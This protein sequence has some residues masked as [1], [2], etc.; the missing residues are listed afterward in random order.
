MA[1][2]DAC[3]F[4]SGPGPGLRSARASEKLA[5]LWGH[6]AAVQLLNKN[7]PA[8]SGCG[9]AFHADTQGALS[10]ERIMRSWRIAPVPDPAGPFLFSSCRRKPTAPKARPISPKPGQTA[11]RDRT[12]NRRPHN[13][14]SHCQRPLPAAS[15]AHHR[16]SLA[17]YLE[18]DPNPPLRTPSASSSTVIPNWTKIPCMNPSPAFSCRTLFS[19]ESFV[20]LAMICPSLS[21]LK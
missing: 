9:A 8:G 6:W 7:G 13:R 21:E 5:V 1:G 10:R 17:H 3:G 14:P 19:L 16:P 12:G 4:S 11:S 15:A 20:I 18:V 2:C